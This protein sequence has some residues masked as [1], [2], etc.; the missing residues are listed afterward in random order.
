[1][2][3]TGRSLT[4]DPYSSVNSTT[5][6][7]LMNKQ[8]IVDLLN[9][10]TPDMDNDTMS[11]RLVQLESG[12]QVSSTDLVTDNGQVGISLSL[13]P[14]NLTADS[15]SLISL[16]FKDPV[17]GNALAADVTYSVEILDNNGKPIIN[18]NS[19]TVL[20]DVEGKLNVMFP[21]KGIYYIRILVESLAPLDSDLVDTPSTGVALGYL[22]VE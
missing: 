8:K 10:R 20:H 13:N 17:T 15:K 3:L 22:L 1:M 12:M 18:Q 9:E 2:P 21:E 7:L 6:H 4:I 16:S 14:K 5:V 19:Q 11:F